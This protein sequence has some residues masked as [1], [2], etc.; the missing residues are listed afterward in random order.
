MGTPR[1]SSCCA[2]SLGA[3]LAQKGC[4]DVLTQQAA[5]WDVELLHVTGLQLLKLS[6]LREAHASFFDT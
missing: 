1:G 5:N 2:K 4:H 6:S 3:G